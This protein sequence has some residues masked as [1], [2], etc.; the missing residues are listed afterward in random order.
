MI[1]FGVVIA[2]QNLSFERVGKTVSLRVLGS[3]IGALVVWTITVPYVGF[4]CRNH[5]SCDVK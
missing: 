2:L 5:T 3:V 1:T 4:F